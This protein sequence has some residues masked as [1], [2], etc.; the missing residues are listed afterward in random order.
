MI[1]IICPHLPYTTW[2]LIQDLKTKREILIFTHIE[3]EKYIV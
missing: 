3:S 1:S 2:G